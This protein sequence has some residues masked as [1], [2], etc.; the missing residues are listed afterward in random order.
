MN[1]VE[2]AQAI[3]AGQVSLGI[4]LGSTRIKAVLVTDDFNTIASGSYVWENRFEDGVWTYPLEEVWSG[5][6]QSYTQMAAD[7]QSKYHASLKHINAIGVSAMMHGY[8]AFDKNNELLVPFRTWRNNITGQ[9][10]DELTKLFDFN[11][12]QR[13]SIAHLYQAVL[14]DEDHVAKVDFI[15]TLAGYVTWKLSGEKVLGVGDASGVFPID[16][17]TGS[18]D[19]AM[20]DKFSSLDNVKRYP[21]QIE[22]ILPSILPAGK[23]AGKLTADGANLLDASGNLEAGSVMAPPEG[24]AGTGMVGTNS[25]RKRTGNISVGTSAFSMNVLDKPLS[26]VYRDIDIVMTPDGSPVAMVHVNNCSS[27]INAWASIFSEFAA[28]LG[29]DLKPDRLYETLFLESTKADANAGG[30]VN[31]SYQSGENIT[32]IQA[33][34]P[35]FVRT[36]NSKFSLPNFM[37]T[38]LY[39]AFAPLQIGMDILVNEEHVQTDVMIAQ[40]GLFR[41]PVIGQ[42]VLANALNIPITVMSTAGEGGPWGMA[43]LAAY[44]QRQTGANLEDFLDQEVFTNPESMTLSPEPAGVAGYQEFIKNYQAGLPVE[45]AAGEAISD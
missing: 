16:E 31:Y 7:V 13:W 22:N 11:I 2:T 29:V 41:T 15:T 21:W 38:Q 40:G 37:L 23:I 30:L 17:K 45:A 44:A 9:S 24:D 27:D 36:P 34:R 33:G 28:R 25:V 3:E 39:A 42:Q 14:N 10:A 8:L 12:P 6:Q 5:I 1:L 35:L 19:Q 4:E 26:K 43:V 32:K 18:Y 20:L